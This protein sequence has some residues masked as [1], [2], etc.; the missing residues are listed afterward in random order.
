MLIEP[1]PYVVQRLFQVLRPND[2]ELLVAFDTV[3]HNLPHTTG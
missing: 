2:A 3:Q 1:V